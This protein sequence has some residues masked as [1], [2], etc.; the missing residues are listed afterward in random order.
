MAT[1]KNGTLY[2]G[3]TSVLKKRV[4]QHKNNLI[5]GF[6]SKYNVHSLVYFEKT[7]DVNSAINEEKR[8]KGLK[9]I[10]KIE[11]IE[12]ENPEWKDLSEGWF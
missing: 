2:T 6:T 7:N 3:V 5:I 8:I 12:K 11:I 4:F 9:R 1:K 10:K